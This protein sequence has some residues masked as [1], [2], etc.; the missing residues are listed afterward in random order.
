MKTT[1]V[2]L[3]LGLLLGTACGN[4]SDE[5]SEYADYVNLFIG[6][7]GHGHTFPGPLRPHG[8]IQPSP[9]TRIYQWD[10]CSGYHYSDSSINGFSHTHLSGTGIG[11]YGDVLIMPTV[12]KQDY[13]YMG[14]ES[15]QTAY[16]S[17]FSHDDEIAEPGYYGVM[18]KRYNV[19]VELAAT[20][21][22]LAL[23]V[24]SPEAPPNS[25]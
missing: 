18:L 14:Y 3:G 17:G 23:D 2:L 19:L 12:G 4:I 8:M 6:T 22:S 13:H 11:D 20:M 24:S 5:K 15:Q 16:A 10:A 7:G 21:D 25:I 1:T 9:D